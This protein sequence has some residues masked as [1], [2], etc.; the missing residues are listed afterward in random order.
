MNALA[1]PVANSFRYESPY[2]G[3]NSPINV[4]RIKCEEFMETKKVGIGGKLWFRLHTGI[5]A[6]AQEAFD[7]ENIPLAQRFSV[8]GEIVRGMQP[9]ID[10]GDGDR[11]QLGQIHVPSQSTSQTRLDSPVVVEARDRK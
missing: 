4:A 6:F 7:A 1:S 9:S 10:C 5:L 2:T 11:I 8:I 3:D